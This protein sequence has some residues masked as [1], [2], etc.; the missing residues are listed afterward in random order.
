MK[1]LKI[2]CLFSLI[3][4]VGCKETETVPGPTVTNTVT[5]KETVQVQKPLLTASQQN[6]ICE[7][8]SRCYV[9]KL[10]IP[11]E[12]I[13]KLNY[14]FSRQP[15]EVNLIVNNQRFTFNEVGAIEIDLSEDDNVILEIR[16]DTDEDLETWLEGYVVKG[17]YYD[18]DDN[19]WKVNF[20]Y[21]KPELH[22][23]I[24]Q[25]TKNILQKVH[26][27]T[28]H[29]FG[30]NNLANLYQAD[31]YTSDGCLVGSGEVGKF[32]SGIVEIFFTNQCHDNL[33]FTSLSEERNYMV[34]FL[35]ITGEPT[36]NILNEG[37]RRVNVTYYD[38]RGRM[39]SNTPNVSTVKREYKELLLTSPY[40]TSDTWATTPAFKFDTIDIEV[41]TDGEY[42][43]EFVSEACPEFECSPRKG[44]IFT[45]QDKK[46]FVDYLW[47]D[48]NKELKVRVYDSNLS[49]VNF[50]ITDCNITDSDWAASFVCPFR[51][52]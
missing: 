44:E 5:V 11:K 14:G 18:A 33:Y 3:S 43:I 30:E 49:R 35:S 15:E 19:L 23:G 22:F 17:T 28:F 6:G 31:I 50:D 51:T 42:Y 52:K 39:S 40:S 37:V 34:R 20:K 2:F 4:I 16:Q 32:G 47:F 25:I 26:S 7:V 38:Q 9:M 12:G 8:E 41:E 45:S 1:F 48:Y 21:Q 13:E 27:V 46:I 10:N 29:I 24:K 36:W